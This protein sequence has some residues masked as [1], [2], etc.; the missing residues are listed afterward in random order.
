MLFIV[1]CN[2]KQEPSKEGNAKEE[3]QKTDS[4][5]PAQTKTWIDIQDAIGDMDST[6]TYS[7]I[8][9]T[10]GK[11]YDEYNSP[12]VPQEYVMFYDVPGVK[13]AF[14]SIMLNSESK[15]FLHWSGEIK[16]K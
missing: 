11:P 3:V 2:S 12:S 10:L 15:T 1:S 8:I 9:E 14:F 13:G 5:E 4:A 7:T 16:E 6:T